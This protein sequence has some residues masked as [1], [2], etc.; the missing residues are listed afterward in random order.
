MRLYK[1]KKII[2]IS[3][4]FKYFYC[5]SSNISDI[6]D[7]TDEYIDLT[8]YALT[9]LLLLMAKLA[10]CAISACISQTRND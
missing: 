5:I 7:M 4:F 10:M 3:I 6:P 9:G 8:V 1:G 2:Y